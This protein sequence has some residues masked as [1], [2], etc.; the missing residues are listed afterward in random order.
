VRR[1]VLAA[2][3][4]ALLA[5]GCGGSGGSDT[6]GSTQAPPS[7]TATGSTPLNTAKPVMP[8]K[9][10]RM[11]DPNFDSGQTIYITP[12]G[13][14]PAWLVSTVHKTITWV[15][16]TDRPVQIQFD[17]IGTDT[18]SPPIAPGKGF[19]WLPTSRASVVYHEA[20]DPSMQGKIQVE[21]KSG[22]L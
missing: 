20:A 2:C 4:L 3:A 11:P 12:K 8:S 14:E 6:G 10:A 1:V 9:G 15:N 18:P 21:P 22:P 16:Q 19:G 17:N 5:A 7:A 13:F